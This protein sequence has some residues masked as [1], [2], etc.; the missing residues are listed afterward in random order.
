MRELLLK[1]FSNNVGG[2]DITLF[3]LFH[4]LYFL[5]IIGSTFALC[6]FT[7]NKSKETKKKILDIM[8]TILV[9]L[10]LGDFFI[11]P[12]IHGENALIVD[13]LPFHICTISCP[14]IAITRIFPNK[15]KHIQHAV[16]VLGLIGSLMYITCPNG[17]VGEGIKAFSYVILQT[18]MYHGLL[19]AY[20]VMTLT[21]GENKLEYKKI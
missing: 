3:G 6:Y 20:G 19:F 1:I 14:L 15:T 5:I 18:F 7:F 9:C 17:A 8:A 2:P 21:T 4:I 10:Y 16:P 12:F 13:K 11:H